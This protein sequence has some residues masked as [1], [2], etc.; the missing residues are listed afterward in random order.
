M[1]GTRSRSSFA[2]CYFYLFCLIDCD[3]CLEISVLH[4]QRM[5]HS[6]LHTMLALRSIHRQKLVPNHLIITQKKATWLGLE[7]CYII[8]YSSPHTGLQSLLT[9]YHLLSSLQV[10]AVC[11]AS[12]TYIVSVT[13]SCS[14]FFIYQ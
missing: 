9:P 13:E 2:C 4:C 3:L 6:L 10:S 8:C 12:S 7:W 5:L 1:V 14:L 11:Y